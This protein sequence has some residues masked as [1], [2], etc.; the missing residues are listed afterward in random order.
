MIGMLTNVIALTVYV[1]VIGIFVI[2][3]VQE[4]NPDSP[5][6]IPEDCGNCIFPCEK[7]KKKGKKK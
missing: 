2:A 7:H 6:K 5:C 3:A 4:P 1:I